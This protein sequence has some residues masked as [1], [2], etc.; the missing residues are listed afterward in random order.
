MIWISVAL[1]LI[2]I[3]LVAVMLVLVAERLKE[4]S[5]KIQESQ[6]GVGQRL[7]SAT[8]IIGNLQNTLGKLEKTNEQIVNIS[9][10][11][12]GLQNLLRAPKFRGE[13]G[14]TL[15]GNLLD[16]VL[17]KEHYRLQYQF[18]NGDTVDAAIILGGNIVPID[19]KFPL[20]NFQGIVNSAAE[21]EKN[22]FRKKFVTDVK[23][24]INEI[25]VKYI[26]PDEKT[27]NFAMMYIPAENVYYET[28]IKQDLL[29]YALSKKVVPVSPNTFYAYL[30][31][32][33]LGLKGMQVERNA[34]EILANL[35]R[36]QQDLFKFTDD[37]RLVGGHIQNARSKFDEAKIKL[38]KFQ[39]KLIS[40]GSGANEKHIQL[41]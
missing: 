14:E 33:L 40:S 7:D 19:A 20:E 26:L 21:D 2:V 8:S 37:F 4:M 29:S 30:E 38:D 22:I 28:T 32:I 24:R 25:S 36:M 35:N 16:Q 6:S 12:S 18:K 39:E 9:K 1:S 41:S 17:P 15:L 5:S 10:D 27:F 3:C 13:M 34:K 23:N 11:I 31:V